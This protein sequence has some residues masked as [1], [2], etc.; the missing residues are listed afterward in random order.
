MV[1]DERALD[2]LVQHGGPCGCL[3]RVWRGVEALRV[4]RAAGATNRVWSADDGDANLVRSRIV[5][6]G[7]EHGG[8]PE[9][10]H[11]S[12]GDEPERSQ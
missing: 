8:E 11:E 10:Q 2:V 7:R 3:G 1:A 6:R 5:E 12:E 4:E 9:Q